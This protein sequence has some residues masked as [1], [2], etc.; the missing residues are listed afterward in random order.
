MAEACLR[1]ETPC[2]RPRFR[3]RS[4]NKVL[5]SFFFLSLSSISLLLASRW[6]LYAWR[7]SCQRSRHDTFVAPF[8]LSLCLSFSLFSCPSCHLS[9]LSSLFHPS[10][11]M[12]T[13]YFFSLF[14]S[15]FFCLF[16]LP[17]PATLLTFQFSF[18]TRSLPTLLSDFYYSQPFILESTSRKSLPKATNVR[19]LN[20]PLKSSL[21]SLFYATRSFLSYFSLSLLSF[22]FCFFVSPILVFQLL[23]LACTVYLL[24]IL[25]VLFQRG[26]PQI[27][28]LISSLSFSYFFLSFSTSLSLWF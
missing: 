17:F 26:L 3:P 21:F 23:Q 10:F 12:M 14:L 5:L 19:P 25:F 9:P 6:T 22:I 18:L 4:E 2:D 28:K 20:S 27:N 11:N 8:S 24:N 1:E 15:S 7:V 16:T 13:F